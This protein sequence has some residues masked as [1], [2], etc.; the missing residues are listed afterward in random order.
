MFGFDVLDTWSDHPTRC[1]EKKFLFVFFTKE[2]NKILKFRAFS[3][4]DEELV[5]DGSFTRN[6]GRCVTSEC[7]VRLAKLVS[8]VT[9]SLLF[10]SNH[11]AVTIQ[12][13]FH[14]GDGLANKRSQVALLGER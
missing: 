1:G 13:L 14:G 5:K 10:V 11:S 9:G 7:V 2:K 4:I 6:G 12:D 8:E 3:L